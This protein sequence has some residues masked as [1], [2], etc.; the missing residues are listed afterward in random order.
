VC[1]RGGTSQRLPG[2]RVR[3][4][5]DDELAA[6]R[7]GLDAAVSDGSKSATV[8]QHAPRLSREALFLLV[9]TS[10]PGIKETL[11]RQ[12]GAAAA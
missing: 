7:A 8:D 2:H 9:F 4:D 12:L 3:L 11:L 5:S 10:R 1:R 6:C